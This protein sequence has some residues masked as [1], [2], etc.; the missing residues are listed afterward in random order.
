MIC[1]LH[2]I[3]I[4]VIRSR[5]MRCVGNVAGGGKGDVHTGIFGR[6]KVKRPLD[7]PRR[8]WQ[9]AVRRDLQEIE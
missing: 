5:R 9:S 8:R 3:L 2:Q 7:R 6:P 4:R 1:T